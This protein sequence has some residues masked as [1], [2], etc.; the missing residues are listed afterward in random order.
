[1]EPQGT[2]LS[3][4]RS[5]AGKGDSARRLVPNRSGWEEPDGNGVGDQVM[6]LKS[7]LGTS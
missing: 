7:L 1:M 3:E 5:C 2:K 6:P 4:D